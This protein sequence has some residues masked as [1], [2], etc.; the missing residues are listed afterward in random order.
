MIFK[1]TRD[2]A[3][4]KSQFLSGLN[5]ILYASD[6]LYIFTEATKEKANIGEIIIDVLR[7]NN[8]EM[9]VNDLQISSE[10]LSEFSNQKI[11]AILFTM[12]KNGLV[13][14]TIKDNKSYFSVDLNNSDNDDNNG[15][16]FFNYFGSLYVEDSEKIV[17]N[18]TYKYEKEDY[19]DT[20]EKS[21]DKEKLIKY[22]NT[23][24]DLNSD[25]YSL[26]QRY[27]FLRDEMLNKI[28]KNVP[29]F[30]KINSELIKEKENIINEIEKNK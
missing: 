29:N 8:K 10:K 3:F 13:N 23:L 26:Q 1:G 7:M 19:L 4:T 5:V 25:I 18:A 15:D 12:V 20:I 17:E 14:K 16:D 6:P 24:I 27:D 22:L 21:I 9:T 28:L 11:S 2:G 30:R